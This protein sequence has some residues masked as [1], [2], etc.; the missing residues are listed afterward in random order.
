MNKR[1]VQ[2]LSF[3][4]FLMRLEY[5]S[6]MNENTVKLVKENYTSQMCSK[7]GNIKKDLGGNKVYKCN[8]CGLNVDRDINSARN[9]LIKSLIE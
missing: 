1:V 7:C 2:S 6:K 4:Q 9:M 5:K 3:Y 8:E